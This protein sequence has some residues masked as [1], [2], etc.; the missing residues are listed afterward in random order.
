MCECAKAGVRKE[1]PIYKGRWYWVF[2]CIHV[3]QVVWYKIP[4]QEE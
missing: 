3:N 4:G 2:Y 1:H